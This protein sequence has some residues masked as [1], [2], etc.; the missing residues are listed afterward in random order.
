MEVPGPDP[1]VTGPANCSPDA[2]TDVS[3]LLQSWTE[4]ES[5]SPPYTCVQLESWIRIMGAREFDEDI[6]KNADAWAAVLFREKK[7]KIGR[8]WLRIQ[9]QA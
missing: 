1:R 5:S 9:S 7:L 3:T 6:A 2:N 8:Q 4:I